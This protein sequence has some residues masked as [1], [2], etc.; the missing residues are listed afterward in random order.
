MT[1][2]EV[3]KTRC[4]WELR[5]LKYFP[6]RPI[7]FLLFLSFSFT[8][9]V[10]AD[11]QFETSLSRN[12][13]NTTESTTFS[14]E[15]KWPKDE[16]KYQFAFPPF[17][18]LE[19]LTL[20]RQGE[21]QETFAGDGGQWMR[22][23][24]NFEMQPKKAGPA[25]IPGFE[26]SYVD[27]VD[28]KTGKFSIPEHTLHVTQKHNLKK[29]IFILVGLGL[30]GFGLA[31][32]LRK[33]FGRWN[34]ETPEENTMPPGAAHID[35]FKHFVE[36]HSSLNHQFSAGLTEH[37]KQFLADAYGVPISGHTIDVA[38]TLQQLEAKGLSRDET[39]EIKTILKTWEEINYAGRVSDVEF[40][41]FHALLL[42]LIQ[43]KKAAISLS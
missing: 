2:E 29:I 43:N 28:Q 24:F 26:L 25:R 14:I 3:C 18:L 1:H 13:I 35:K 39:Y 30:F 38:Q 22:K 32:R 42:R 41:E 11:P 20:V 31:A 33:L 17:N 5:T 15:V 19:N 27:P 8:A 40:R 6:M 23:I 36:T 7:L 16:A 34:Q 12:K 21:S 4:L 9:S 37:S 10:F